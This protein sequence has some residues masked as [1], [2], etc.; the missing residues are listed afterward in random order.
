[1][2]D[3]SHTFES[4]LVFQGKIKMVEM[5]RLGINLLHGYELT[6]YS[7]I[8]EYLTQPHWDL[9]TDIFVVTACSAHCQNICL[10]SAVFPRHTTTISPF[11]PNHCDVNKANLAELEDTSG[12]V[13]ESFSRAD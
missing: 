3:H 10:L 5:K 11:L 9:R 6:I 2:P 7:G 1:M 12:S 4:F 8:A 13:F